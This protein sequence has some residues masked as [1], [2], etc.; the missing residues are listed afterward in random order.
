MRILWANLEKALTVVLVVGEVSWLLL[1]R[2]FLFALARG[3]VPGVALWER[4]TQ[5]CLQL[6]PDIQNVARE[7]CSGNTKNT[8]WLTVGSGHSK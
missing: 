8:K 4:R 3:Y 1:L 5:S 7:L 2:I 6:A